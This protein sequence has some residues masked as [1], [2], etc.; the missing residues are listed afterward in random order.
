MRTVSAALAFLCLALPAAADRLITHDGRILD[1]D[2]ARLL[3]DGS[4]RLEF[5]N[6]VILCPAALVASVEMEGDMSDYKPANEDEK[7]KLAEGF[8]R[9]RGKWM[10]K[11]AY[12]AEM[13]R[14]A[15]TRRKRTD[16][17]AQHARF[18]DG[19]TKD[20][21]H[22]SFKT[23]TSPELLDYYAD[24][25]EA[26][27]DLM[28]E[29]LGIKPS[30]SL[31]RTQMQVNI[32]KNE[33]EF[34]KLSGAGYGVLG[35][36]DFR[37]EE[38]QFFHDYQEPKKSEWVALHEGT[39][40][41]TYLIEPQAWPQIW[42]NEG[43]ADYFGM[44]KITRDKKGRI[45]IQPGEL[46]VDRV[47]TVQQAIE[48]GEYIPLDKLFFI[49][50]SEYRGFEYAHGWS[51]VYYLQNSPYEKGFKRFFKELYTLPKGVAY[52]SE[53][54][55]PNQQGV[56]KIVPPPEV[57]RLLLDRLGVKDLAKLE[58][59]WLAFVK[60]IP[61]DAPLALYKRGLRTY[62]TAGDKEAQ[63]RGRD[64]IEAAIAGG[65]EDARA[66][67][68]RGMYA[69]EID[70]DRAKCEEN[71]RKAI[72][73]APLEAEF[74]NGLAGILA[75]GLSVGLSTGG[76]SIQVKDADEKLT[77]TPEELG[78]AKELF[79]LACEL[80]PDNDYYQDEYAHF[81]ELYEKTGAK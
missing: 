40:L 22:F 56:A 61:I 5:E 78:E 12:Q 47:L 62:Y 38:L 57:K 48:D 71:L 6:G 70:G 69:L 42:I 4:Y 39:H 17:L 10:T 58:E 19:W 25:L 50:R 2:K 46:Q 16:D 28:D 7:K 1:V 52:D 26:Y 75:G 37:K 65:I 79:G 73:I 45:V 36:F 15:E 80:D 30:P 18:R 76:I 67:W 35:F 8:V 9:L 23:N 33:A 54:G 77:G 63:Q 55:F 81:L 13:A 51:L 66:Y 31:R 60:A 34:H 11:V 49:D 29:R 20:T 72:D 3:P 27:Y 24:L 21:K 14:E 32:Y 53:N 59:Q 43:V 44:S 68:L 64:D 74:R 41:L